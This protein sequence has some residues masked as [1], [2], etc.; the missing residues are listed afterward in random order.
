MSAWASI[1][2][3]LRRALLRSGR[4]RPVVDEML[5]ELNRAFVVLERVRGKATFAAITV[6]HVTI[7]GWDSWTLANYHS[8][9]L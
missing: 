4:C 2:P 7:G 8:L 1:E 9:H 3:D 6:L 5:G